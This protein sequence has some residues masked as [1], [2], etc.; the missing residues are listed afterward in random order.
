[1]ATAGLTMACAGQAHEMKVLASRLAVTKAGDRTT[2]YLSWGHV[3][4]V[5]DLTDSKALERYERVSPDGEVIALKSEGV[6]L[7][8]NVVEVKEEGVH[9]LIA[10]RKP[11]TFTFVK[12]AEGNRTFKRGPKSLVKEGEVDYG[13]REQQFAKALIVVGPPKAE[14]VKPSGLPIEIVPV[15]GPS[16]WRGGRT[17]HFRAV[18]G[19]KPLAH[20]QVLATYVGF[21]PDDAWC[22]AGETNEEGT[23]AVPVKAG[24]WVLRV[25]RRK[26][27]RGKDRDEFDYDALTATLALEVRP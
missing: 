23:V 2:V 9:Q 22:F 16:R 24:T 20:E 7:Q 1:M 12:D 8:V 15:E 10:A 25:E 14:A 6:S 11:A 27:A 26:P 17:L 3:L 13:M 4:P 21:R 18:C 19:G 5:D